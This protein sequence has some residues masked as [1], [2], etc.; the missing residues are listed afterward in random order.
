MRF[1]IGYKFTNVADKENLKARVL[2]IAYYINSKG[3]ETFVLGRDVQNWHSSPFPMIKTLPPVFTNML[4]ANILLSVI[5][6]NSRSVGLLVENVLAMLFFKKRYYLVKSGVGENLYTF[7]ANV[8]NIV[9]YMT[10][11]DIESSIQKLLD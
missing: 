11:A 4:K 2:K 7:F 5:S 9:Y 1:Y 6:D 10:D 8:D 3:H